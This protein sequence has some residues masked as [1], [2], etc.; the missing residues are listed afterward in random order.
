MP[1]VE[2]EISP[3]PPGSARSRQQRRAQ[4]RQMT[5]AQRRAQTQE[6]SPPTRAEVRCALQLMA[7]RLVPVD[8]HIRSLQD[9]VGRL[10][11]MLLTI[12]RALLAPRPRRWWHRLVGRYPMPFLTREQLDTV[13]SGVLQDVE[14]R[15]MQE[16]VAAQILQEAKQEIPTDVSDFHPKG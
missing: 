4:G 10:Q 7:Q 15:R 12:E 1:E 6:T 14:A 8:V 11:A 2:V 5:E 9:E 13:L 16:K 3:A